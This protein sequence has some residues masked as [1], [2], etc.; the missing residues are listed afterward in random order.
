[1]KMP[2]FLLKIVKSI[3]PPEEGPEMMSIIVR[4]PFSHLEKEFKSTFEGQ[5]D[6]DIIVDRR[7]SERRGR[8]QPYEVE[9]RQFDRRRLKEEIAEVLF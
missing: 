1:M 5:G 3:R 4:R 8:V 7:Y 2:E 9:L 6:V